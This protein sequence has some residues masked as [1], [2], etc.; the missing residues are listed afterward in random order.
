M[1]GQHD[2]RVGW[3]RLEN[4]LITIKPG[5][6]ITVDSLATESGLLPETVEI[7]LNALT[8]AELF[9]RKDGNVFVR[10]RLFQ[11]G[12][13]GGGLERIRPDLTRHVRTAPQLRVTA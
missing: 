2:P 13:F 10:R 8:K 12:G 11:T 5:E 3:N 6:T 4:T 7:V 9:E 1:T